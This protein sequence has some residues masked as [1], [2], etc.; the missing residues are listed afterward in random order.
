MAR[1][2]RVSFFTQAHFKSK[3]VNRIKIDKMLTLRE[4]LMPNLLF[5]KRILI[6]LYELTNSP[7]FISEEPMQRN[8][9]FW[10]T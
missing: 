3:N 2:Q 4:E 5:N 8:Q 7:Y 1:A 6:K 9:L 10:L